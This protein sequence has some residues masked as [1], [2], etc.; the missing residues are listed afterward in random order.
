MLLLTSGAESA[1]ASDD[2]I[3]DV[4]RAER[5]LEEGKEVKSVA[6]CSESCWAF[7]NT[8]PFTPSLTSSW[9]L[10]EVTYQKYSVDGWEDLPSKIQST[11]R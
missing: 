10:Q 7:V 4:R 6:I 2:S 11:D 1:G 8:K 3:R 5:A 9:R